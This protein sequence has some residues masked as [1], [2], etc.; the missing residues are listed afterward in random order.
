AGPRVGGCLKWNGLWPG[1]SPPGSE[2]SARYADELAVAGA[3]SQRSLCVV[4]LGVAVWATTAPASSAAQTISELRKIMLH[5]LRFDGPS[6]Y[7]GGGATSA[8]AQSS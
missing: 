2:R 1:V 4:R 7:A 3:A 5:L 6:L 8:R